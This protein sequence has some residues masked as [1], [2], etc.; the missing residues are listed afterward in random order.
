MYVYM[1]LHSR[2]KRILH[3]LNIHTMH[4]LAMLWVAS[5][6]SECRRLGQFCD[7]NPLCSTRALLLSD[8]DFVKECAC[9]QKQNEETRDHFRRKHNHDDDVK[10]PAGPTPT[11]S[12]ALL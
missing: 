4:M 1:Y 7:W 2:L 10:P 6:F 11:K 12:H 3:G 9:G 5:F 8:D